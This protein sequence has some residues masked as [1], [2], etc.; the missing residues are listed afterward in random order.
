MH[1]APRIIWIAFL[2]LSG[3]IALGQAAKKHAVSMKDM[4]YSPA[5]LEIKVGD[6]VVWTNNDTRDH[7]VVAAG[8]AFKSENIRPGGTFSYRFSRA[9]TFS[10]GCSYHPRMKG[11]IKVTAPTT[12]PKAN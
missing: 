3:S 2:A 10:Y 1:S 7:T 11:T 9:G 6:S 4:A 12:A 5:T 8:N